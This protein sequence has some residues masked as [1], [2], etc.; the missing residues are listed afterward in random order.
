V[1]RPRWKTGKAVDEGYTAAR[2]AGVELN[3]TFVSQGLND[4]KRELTSGA[5]ARAG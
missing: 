2:T 3:P 4:I 5:N 1:A